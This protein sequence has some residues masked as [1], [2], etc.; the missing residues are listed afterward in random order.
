MESRYI[1]CRNREEPEGCD[2]AGA[3]YLE[4]QSRRKSASDTERGNKL[5][6]A[7]KISPSAVN[8]PGALNVQQTFV[9]RRPERSGNARGSEAGKCRLRGADQARG[10]G[11]T[12]TVLPFPVNVR[13]EKTD[14]AR[15]RPVPEDTQFPAALLNALVCRAGCRR[16]VVCMEK[17]PERTFDS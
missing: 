10:T 12:K 14:A 16:Q 1:P 9:Q 7:T 5:Q 6:Q 4:W 17:E 8:P 11:K 2:P 13:T 15:G 3:G